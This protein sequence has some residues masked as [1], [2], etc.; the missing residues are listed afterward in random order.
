MAEIGSRRVDANGD[1]GSAHAGSGEAEAA[2]ARHYSVAHPPNL[3]IGGSGR[4]DIISSWRR[5]HGKRLDLAP[6]DEDERAL[7]DEDEEDEEA[8]E[9][10]LGRQAE[11]ESGRGAGR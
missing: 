10:R 9:E 3:T 4:G 11:E 7:D 5:E 2:T 1:A 6:S 8:M